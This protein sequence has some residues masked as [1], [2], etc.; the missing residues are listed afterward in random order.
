[1]LDRASATEGKAAFDGT[2][3]GEAQWQPLALPEVPA[4]HVHTLTAF[5]RRRA[6]PRMQ[7]GGH[8][9]SF[10]PQW[11]KELP[12]IAE[13]WTLSLRIDEKPAEIVLPEALIR[14]LLRE[15]DAAVSFDSLSPDH[16]ALI[17]EFALAD[18]LEL[19]ETVLGCALSLVSAR[20]APEI[21]HLQPEPALLVSF[22][23]Q[24]LDPSWVLLRV[25]EAHVHR[26]ARGLDRIAGE[27]AA[28]DLIDLAIPTRLR[29]ASVD[30]TLADLK[31][32]RPGDIILVDSYCQ[33]SET[34]LA[35]IGGHLMAPVKIL[36]KGYQL[37]E[38]AKRIAGSGFE[39]CGEHLPA[40]AGPFRDA[41][42][43]DVP[44]RLFVDMAQFSLSLS[45]LRGLSRG[46]Q[47][48]ADAPRKPHLDLMVGNTPVGWG[49]LTAL[50]IGLGLRI[51]RI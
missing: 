10:T 16:R 36:P 3:D 32:L 47:I 28:A 9:F 2:A 34:A 29:W 25:G 13:P 27:P 23:L 18:M 43:K 19:M 31:S 42:A 50:G 41:A 37:L 5:Y 8:A 35:V 39:W 40:H 21:R 17:L 38:P 11:R 33:E 20:R 44:I 6:L 24:G 26:L 7:L 46:A 14:F 49:E 1:M 48:G 15:V 4:H 22:E 12:A 45:E 51:L 30:M